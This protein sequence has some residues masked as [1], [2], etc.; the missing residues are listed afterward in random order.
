MLYEKLLKYTA[1]GVYPMHMPGHKRN[2]ELLPPGFPYDIDITE[3]HGFDDLH[4]PSGVLLETSE[5]ASRLYGSMK[6]FLLVNGST[7]GILTAIGAHASRG[8]KILVARN[9]HRSV[10]NAASL[11]GLSPVYLSPEV[12]SATGI[13]CSVDPAAI[14]SELCSTPEIKLIVVTS[15]SYEGVISDI[16]SISDVVHK[17]GIPLIVDGAHGAHLGFSPK[18]TRC[19]VREGADVVVMSLHKTLPA[20][21]QCSLLH[22]CSERAQTDEVSRMLSVLQTSSPSYVLLAST[23]RC[24]RLLESDRDRLFTEYERN[25]DLFSERIRPLKNLKVLYHGNDSGKPGFF[26]FDPGKI[27]IVTK[28]TA[29]SGMMLADVLRADHSIELELARNDYAVAMTSIC[30]G[31]DGFIRLADALL[32]VDNDIC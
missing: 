16:G 23:D 21:T 6:A 7:V 8:D 4:N 5:L 3:I 18:F 13:V 11:Y 28:H 12:D 1:G 29:M 17:H 25:L 2:K 15:P 19:A 22:I 10:E 24:L 9:C 20:L 27:V 32:A 14:E 31:K 26:A 30:D